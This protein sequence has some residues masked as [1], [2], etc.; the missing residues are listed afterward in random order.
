MAEQCRRLGIDVETRP[1]PVTASSHQQGR[2]K[3]RDLEGS[4]EIST[5]HR[6]A[7]NLYI[8]MI[9]LNREES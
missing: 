3:P 1:L 6:R 4:L 7:I 2:R 8:Y 5:I 9:E